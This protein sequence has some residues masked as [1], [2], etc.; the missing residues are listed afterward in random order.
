MIASAKAKQRS[1]VDS[2]ASAAAV[3]AG[4]LGTLLTLL[5]QLAYPA[6][7]H[8]PMSASLAGQSA[9]R[10]IPI[11]AEDQQFASQMLPYLDDAYNFARY[12]SRDPDAAQDI[13]QEAYLRAYRGFSGYR[14]GDAKAWLLTIVRNTF[15]TW[16]RRRRAERQVE[17]PFGDVEA[18]RA[19]SGDA[20][21]AADDADT[22]EGALLRASESR[23]VRRI[24]AGL[25]AEMREVVVLRDLENLSYRQIATV[26]GVPMG[27]VMSRLAR[28]RKELGVRWKALEAGGT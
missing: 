26:L 5:S 19:E 13:V 14:G 17:R 21:H 7:V 3:A 24:I 9:A 10:R 25:P 23:A 2:L 8:L 22:P 12:L 27:T 20:F 4:R 1:V 6:G 15:H 18:G 11:E 16:Y 28:A